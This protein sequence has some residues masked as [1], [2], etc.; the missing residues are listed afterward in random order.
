MRT[1]WC[2]ETDVVEFHGEFNDLPPMH[3]DPRPIQ[4][5]IPILVGGHSDIALARAGRVG[6]GW[7]S[8][9]MSADR[10]AEHW[11]KVKAAAAEADHDPEA[12]VLVAMPSRRAP[13]DGDELS[14]LR[15]YEEVGVDILN[16]DARRDTPEATLAELRRLGEAVLPHFG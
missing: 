11:G 7:I 4:R 2:A 1:L 9:A 8:A 14:F 5:P 13:E 3:P 15:A 16:V 10:V 12:L 6:D